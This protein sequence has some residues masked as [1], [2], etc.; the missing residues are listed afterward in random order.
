MIPLSLGVLLLDKSGVLAWFAWFMAP[1]MRLAGLPGE[2]ALV[3]LSSLFL[4]IYSAIAV[5][6]TL[7]LPARDLVILASLCC[8]AHN[9][10]VECLVMKRTGSS[11]VRIALLRFLCAL[12]VAG[13]LNRL[14]PP[15]PGIPPPL[16]AA[17]GGAASLPPIGLDLGELPSLIVS[18]L[19]GTGFLILR[20]VLIIFVI[21][22]FQKLLEAFGFIRLLGRLTVP[23]MRILGLPAATGYL[24][25]VA[26]M[27]GVVYGSAILIEEIRSGRINPQDA[28]LF[29]HHAAVSHAQL[30]DTLLFTALGV[31]FLWAALPRFFMA[32]LVV[33]LERFR[34][35]LFRRSFRV[36]FSK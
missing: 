35:F 32:I 24:W 29:N 22:F 21:I 25:I 3:F 16:E 14:L 19:R 17:V 12:A 6:E 2:A 10:F 27:I 13:V 20:I 34:R 1:L 33:W 26:S 11:L 9:F 7:K 36:S 8:I 30:E 4:N 5:I 18:W 15:A 23:L 31:P 28:D